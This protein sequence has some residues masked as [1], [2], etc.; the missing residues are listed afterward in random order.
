M[1]LIPATNYDEASK[2]AAEFIAVQIKGKSDSVLGLATGGSPVGIYE[3]LVDAYRAGLDFSQVR[4]VNLDEYVGLASD[5]PQSYAYY[6]HTN[7]FRH[8]NISLDNVHIPDGTDRNIQQQCASYDRLIGELGGIDL[9][10]LGIGHNGHIGFNEP[11]TEFTKGTHCVDLTQTTIEA[12]AR[13]FERETDVPVKAYTMGILHIMQAK[14]VL[15]IACGSDKA[16]I[17]HRAFYGPVTP[18]VPASILQFHPNF[19]LIA[20]NQALQYFNKNTLN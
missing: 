17:L 20:D 5:H 19:T 4:T 15:M 18:E 13:Y 9:Q 10:L 8:I 11:S 16:R 6:M 14:K 12:N 7:L 2:K 1:N 3:R